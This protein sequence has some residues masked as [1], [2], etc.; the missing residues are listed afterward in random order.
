M[1]KRTR[2]VA[3]GRLMALILGTLL[4]GLLP[5]STAAHVNSAAVSSPDSTTTS[6]SISA[7]DWSQIKALINASAA[8]TQQ[9]YLKASNA[10][11]YDQFGVSV[12]ISGDTVVVGAPYESSSASGGEGDNSAFHSGAAYVF[13]RS[14]SSWSQQAYLKASNAGEYDLFGLSVA[15]DGDTIVV[16]AV[17]ESSSASGGESDNSAFAAG[18]AYV[19]TRSGSSWS[20]QAYL[21]ASNADEY[22]NFGTSVAIDG[23]TVVVGAVGESAS[24]GAAYVFTRS[25]S[26]WSQQAYLKASNAESSDSFGCS[27]AISGDSVVVGAYGESSS[28]SGGES[29]NSASFV[30]AA[31][32]FTRSGSSWSQQ[33]YLKASNAEEY[34]EFGIS[35]AISG[36]SVVVGADDDSSASGGESDNSAFWAGAAYVFTRSGSSWSQQA[37]LKASNAEAGDYFGRFGRHRRRHCRRRLR[38]RVQQRK[39]WRE[40]Q[41]SVQRR[42][43]ICLHA[44]GQQLEPAGI[45]EGIERRSGRQV[46]LLAGD[47]RRH[48]CRRRHHRGQQRERRR[49]R[50]L[51]VLLRRGICLLLSDSVLA[52]LLLGYR[53]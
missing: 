18:A 42:R 52:R 50:Q 21:K 8:P 31:Y 51:N 22:N 41:L 46:R 28:A 4:A 11:A 44:I 40:R 38:L 2:W 16:G 3:Q 17:V 9:A 5:A 32:V 6:Q 34:D 43:G 36:D 7:R 35:V 26:A 37:Y 12:A 10:D 29:D 1:A 14:G 27:V 39:R 13:T 48:C 23:D 25:G 20:Q 47:R 49:G 30:G 24:A 45:P 19:F 15:I 53:E 33:A